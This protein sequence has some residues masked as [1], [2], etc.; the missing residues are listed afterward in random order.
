MNQ[1]SVSIRELISRAEETFGA[2]RAFPITIELVA[3]WQAAKALEA[4][5]PEV[6]AHVEAA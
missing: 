2:D 5:T 4:L 6:L 1:L 3:A